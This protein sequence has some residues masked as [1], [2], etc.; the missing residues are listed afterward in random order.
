MKTWGELQAAET[1]KQAAEDALK[2]AQAQALAAEELAKQQAVAAAKAAADADAAFTKTKNDLALAKQSNKKKQAIAKAFATGKPMTDEQDAFWQT[3]TSDEKDELNELAEAILNNPKAAKP[4]TATKSGAHKAPKPTATKPITA[5]GNNPTPAPDKLTFVRG[6]GGTTGAELHKDS[7]GALYVVKRGAK[8]DHVREESMADDIYRALG[9]RVPDG[10][11]HET[12]SGPVKVTRFEASAIPLRD[13]LA[14]P[15][16]AAKVKAAVQEDFA[17]DVLLGNWDVAGADLDNI[18]VTADNKVIRIDNGGA[19]RFRAMGTAKTPADWDDTPSELF[20]MRRKD[21]PNGT[22]LPP[23]G[24]HHGELFGDADWL[25][26]SRRIEAIDRATLEALP[27]DPAVKETLLKRHEELAIVAR[28]TLNQDHDGWTATFSERQAALSFEFKAKG[29][30]EAIPN[31]I[32]VAVSA[33]GDVKATTDGASGYGR[34]RS[35]V[36]GNQP[37]APDPSKGTVLPADTFFQA[38]KV[39]VTNI[40]YHA[41]QGSDAINAL[42]I[43]NALDLKP[44]IEKILAKEKKASHVK[45]MAQKY[46]EQLKKIEA[47]SKTGKPTV[48][49]LFEQYLVPPTT[50]AAAITQPVKNTSIVAEVFNIVLA[51][52]G[53]AGR[54]AMDVLANWMDAQ[55]GNSWNPAARVA[56]YWMARQVAEP[57]KLFWGGNGN[58]GASSLKD[59]AK[60]WDNA[61]LGM[62]NAG[63]QTEATRILDDVFFHWHTMTQ[64]VLT[65]ADMPYN[66]RARGVVRLVRTE[67]PEAVALAGT[68]AKGIQRM[69]RG[70]VESHSIFRK[71]TVKGDS[72]IAFWIAT[73]HHRVL[74]TYLTERTPGAAYS[75]FAGNDENEFASNTSMLAS[76][77]SDTDPSGNNQ[78]TNASEWGVPTDHLR[79]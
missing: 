20:T 51:K 45:T 10:T 4:A 3:L 16:R 2:L 41:S 67:S 47:I 36:A 27:I 17:L 48:L 8:P 19:L 7:D 13:A 40:N 24:A 54:Q 33:Y 32:E 78:S 56:K 59:A 15:K 37:K 61:L 63:N 18:L 44:A 9:V 42:K 21:N 43:K 49:P 60:H 52:H 11:L 58:S 71:T 53:E 6:L 74:G 5:L 79:K 26:I 22:T 64:D 57:E 62:T 38:I 39:A 65:W 35:A 77:H 23:D 66:D 55:A 28:R 76:L 34:L 70:A 29:V 75:G 73:P 68:A 69:K 72:T 46:L 14:D 1:A 50:A 25:Q 30:R 31:R 12:A